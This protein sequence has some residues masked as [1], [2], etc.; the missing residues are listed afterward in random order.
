MT[1]YFASSNDVTKKE[2]VR[3]QKRWTLDSGPHL[4]V[5]ASEV[6]VPEHKAGVTDFTQCGVERVERVKLPLA[7][8][9]SLELP[10]RKDLWIKGPCVSGSPKNKKKSN[11]A[12]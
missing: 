3:R 9:I 11:G 6:A 8:D 7:A 5:Q 10:R 2:K 1:K 4:Q 12:M